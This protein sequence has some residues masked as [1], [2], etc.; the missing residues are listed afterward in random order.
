MASKNRRAA[1]RA[2]RAEE[3]VRV[4]VAARMAEYREVL[5][6]DWSRT[7]RDV[8]RRENRPVTGRGH[9]DMSAPT[10]GVGRDIT[11]LSR[12]SR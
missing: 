6:G 12:F 3:A 7:R 9:L 5:Q 10:R 1:R 11:M 4:E 2:Y 8:K